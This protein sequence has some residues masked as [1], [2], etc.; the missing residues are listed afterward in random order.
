[1]GLKVVGVCAEELGRL[2]QGIDSG[3]EGNEVVDATGYLFIQGLWSSRRMTE[4]PHAQFRRTLLDL[5]RV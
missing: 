1:M 5:Q 2:G 4:D 3:G